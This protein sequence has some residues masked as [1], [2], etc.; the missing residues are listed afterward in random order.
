MQICKL[1]LKNW[2]VRLIKKTRKFIKLE[3]RE[4]L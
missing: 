2:N 3:I 4:S 1:K